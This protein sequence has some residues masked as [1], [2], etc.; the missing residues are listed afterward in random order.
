[1]HTVVAG[2]TS[3]KLSGCQDF[4]NNIYACIEFEYNQSAEAQGFVRL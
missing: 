3:G 2:Q 4:F 1:M